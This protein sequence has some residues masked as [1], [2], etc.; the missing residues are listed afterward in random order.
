MCGK[1]WT[2]H[3]EKRKSSVSFDFRQVKSE[4]FP[5]TGGREKSNSCSDIHSASFITVSALLNL[6]R[7]DM[8][9]Q[10]CKRNL[11]FLIHLWIWS[12]EFVYRR[13]RISW[14]PVAP[15]SLLE[16]KLGQRSDSKLN[17]HC[18]TIHSLESLHNNMFYWWNCIQYILN[19]IP[20]L[21]TL[22]STCQHQSQSPLWKIIW[23]DY[24]C[25]FSSFMKLMWSCYEDFMAWTLPKLR[26]SATGEK[27]FVP[28]WS[29][30]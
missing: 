18:S 16:M 26:Q 9:T 29:C 28:F 8:Q 19:S 13:M 6:V 1:R 7:A 4:N 5:V 20:R 10:T 12:R 30:I 25:G 14:K 24:F 23:T 2:P 3:R 27:G 21:V 11:S 22:S 17:K 15:Y